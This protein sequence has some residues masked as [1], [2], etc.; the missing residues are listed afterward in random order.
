MDKIGIYVDGDALTPQRFWSYA[1]VTDLNKNGTHEFIVKQHYIFDLKNT[2]L[3][4]SLT[5]EQK[6]KITFTYID[7]E[8]QF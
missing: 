7:G 5:Q 3:Y 6:E 2:N 1:L 4:N 8:K